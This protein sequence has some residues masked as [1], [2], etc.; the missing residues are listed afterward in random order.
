MENN[1]W[2]EHIFNSKK[3]K[4]EKS[5]YIS[6]TGD[7]CSDPAVAIT[8]HTIFAWHMYFQKS[9]HCWILEPEIYMAAFI[10]GEVYCSPSIPFLPQSSLKVDSLVDYWICVSEWNTQT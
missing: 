6:S 9:W 5:T 7:L 4:K 8:S 3:K 10:A 2:K 1:Y